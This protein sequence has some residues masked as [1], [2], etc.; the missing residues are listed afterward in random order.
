MAHNPIIFA[1]LLVAA[2][3]FFVWS[4]ARRI[5][6]IGHGKFENR[7]DHLPTRIGDMLL[8]AFGQKKVVSKLF[9]LNHAILFGSFLI[10]LLANGEFMVQ[11]VFPNIS[12]ALLPP[13]LH[14]GLLLAF[15][16][17][18]ALTLGCVVIALARRLF[19]KPN[20]L[21]SAYVKGRSFEGFL[22]L[23]F[24]ALLMVA[25]LGLGGVRIAMGLEQWRF[26]PRLPFWGLIAGGI[27]QPHGAG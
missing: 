26:G 8:Y 27:G 22:I 3:L 5:R 7:F 13:T 14:Q 19:F 18:S 20:Y 10:L 24:I 6:L 25:Y 9:G 2:L 17:V 1:V 11:G 23:A 4:C 21:D 16:I 12:L 15:D